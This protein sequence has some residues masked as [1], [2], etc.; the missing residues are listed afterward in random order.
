VVAQVEPANAASRHALEK[1]GMTA[2]AE[3]LADSR[4]QVLYVVKR[5]G[6][7]PSEARGEP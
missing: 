4:P 3:R 7:P 1:L 6:G 5:D 2:R